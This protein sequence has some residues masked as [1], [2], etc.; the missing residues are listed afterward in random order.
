M[1]RENGTRFI[2]LFDRNIYVLVNKQHNHIG[3]CYIKP[4]AMKLIKKF[5]MNDLHLC[6]QACLQQTHFTHMNTSM[7]YSQT[8]NFNSTRTFKF[9]HALYDSTP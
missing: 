9:S 5:G 8:Q 6:V 2:N 3:K 1:D 4:W 7:A